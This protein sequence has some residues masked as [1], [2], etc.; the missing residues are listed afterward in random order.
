MAVENVYFYKMSTDKKTKRRLKKKTKILITS[1]SDD[2]LQKRYLCS[3]CLT[4]M[5]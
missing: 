3:E 2:I 5:I 4:R 1:L